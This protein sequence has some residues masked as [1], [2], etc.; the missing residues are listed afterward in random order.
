MKVGREPSSLQFVTLKGSRVRRR[1]PLPETTEPEPARGRARGVV[2][3]RR[4]RLAVAGIF[5]VPAALR[6]LVSEDRGCGIIYIHINI[7]RLA[8]ESDR[9]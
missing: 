2:R 3:K 1:W 9:W 8:A 4:R 7:L 6:E 5:R